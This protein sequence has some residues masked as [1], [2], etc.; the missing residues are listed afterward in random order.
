MVKL[1]K[2][3]KAAGDAAQ[4]RSVSK[5][6]IRRN[7]YGLIEFISVSPSYQAGIPSRFKGIV[8]GALPGAVRMNLP[9]VD[10]LQGKY[11]YVLRTAPAML[12][13]HRMTGSLNISADILRYSRS[14][15]AA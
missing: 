15:A 2:S 7:I 6:R 4:Q 10:I 13:Y 5:R 1:Q 12:E 8:A 14:R 9:H 3:V 11:G